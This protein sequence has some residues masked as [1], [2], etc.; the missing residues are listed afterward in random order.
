M[1]YNMSGLRI[2]PIMT[3]GNIDLTQSLRSLDSAHIYDGRY[4]I[5]DTAHTQT[6]WWLTYTDRLSNI[7]DLLY[8]P[9]LWTITAQ[10]AWSSSARYKLN[11]NKEVLIKS[12]L[13]LYEEDAWIQ[14]VQKDYLI[15]KSLQDIIV[16]GNL[17]QESGHV[18][19]DIQGTYGSAYQFHIILDDDTWDIN[20]SDHAHLW[21][22][23]H[24]ICNKQAR[25]EI[26]IAQGSMQILKASL[27]QNIHAT[28]HEY[29]MNT[30]TTRSSPNLSLWLHITASGQ[31]SNKDMETRILPK[32]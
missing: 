21:S 9:W 2:Y 24:I 5:A 18:V 10:Q 23:R 27:E 26:N 20:I 30:Y 16:T 6:F 1:V 29:Q 8:Q 12:I 22:K 3:G 11:L 17:Y 7:R 31:V 32:N 4:H 14:Q 25:C 15:R 13:K 19:W 28:E